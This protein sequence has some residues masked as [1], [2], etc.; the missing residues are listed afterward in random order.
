MAS[1]NPD[2]NIT[3]VVFIDSSLADLQTILSG[4]APS[5][6]AIVLDPTRDGIWRNYE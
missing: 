4:L 6:T 5:V 3:F 1:L 2:R